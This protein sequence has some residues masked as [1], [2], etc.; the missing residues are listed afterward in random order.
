MEGREKKEDYLFIDLNNIGFSFLEEKK[1][2]EPLQKQVGVTQKDDLNEKIYLNKGKCKARYYKTIESY[3]KD[4]SINPQ[5]T[6]NLKQLSILY[7][8]VGKLSESAETIDKALALEPENE[9]F[10]KIKKLI[11]QMQNEKNELLIKSK[12]K[13]Y[14]E[15]EILCKKLLEEAPQAYDIQKEYIF[16]LINNN[17]YHE[18]LLFLLNDVSEENKNVYKDLNFYLALSFYYESRY[19]EAK[20]LIN[21]LKNKEIKDDLKKQCENILKSIESNESVINEGEKLI[22]N[23]KYDKAI[24]FYNSEL[25]KKENNKAFNSL[26]LSKKAFVYY[27]MEKYN[28]ALEDANKSINLNPNYSYSY[29]IRGMIKTQIKSEDAK[30]DLAKAKEVDPLLLNLKKKINSQTEETDEISPKGKKKPK[31]DRFIEQIPCIIKSSDDNNNIER[32]NKYLNKIPRNKLTI[33]K[34]NISSIKEVENKENNSIINDDEISLGLT[35]LK[36]GGD[37]KFGLNK[38]QTT[39]YE[40]SSIVAKRILYSISIDEEEDISFNASFL[41]KIEKIAKLECS[42]EQKAE[43]LLKI[44]QNIGLY[45]PLKMYIG[46]LYRFNTEKMNKE[47]KKEFLSEVSAQAN[48][49]EFLVE[50]KSAFHHKKGEEKSFDFLR[51]SSSCIGGEMSKDYQEWI[52]TVKI[53]NSDFI[54]Y[55]QF[56][57][58]FDFLNEDLKKQLSI[59][60]NIIK[61]KY[62]RKI[63]YMKI[64][65]QLKNNKGEQLFLEDD[66]DLPE[67]YRDRI[68]FK[69][70]YEK[71]KSNDVEVK[72]K[73]ND[74]IIGLKIHSLKQ[75]NGTP[76]F[77]NPLLKNEINIKFEP[78]LLCDMNYVIKVYLMKYPE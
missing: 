4:L 30:E 28:E 73:Y 58:I 72:K 57:E 46:G 6:N 32:N 61:K 77:D 3:K 26:L 66:E 29:V 65:E 24:S 60:I 2:E 41:E 78:T 16:S 40:K 52:K 5:D 64:F 48:M 1:D 7:K 11:Q 76:I 59:P 8:K 71:F 14:S 35:V 50:M 23:E 13:N 18:L 67:I 37:I 19:E 21:Q 70:T 75:F 12:D 25:E 63:N 51:R 20:E 74:I 9:E 47:E 10:I 42:D 43:E 31:V 33:N 15:T 38:N 39:N 54:Q 17:K 49:E 55:S 45:I 36:K 69:K 34:E 44:I 56:R 22:K 53:D 27:L 68:S 62:K